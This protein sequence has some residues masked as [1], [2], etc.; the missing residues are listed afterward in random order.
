MTAPIMKKRIIKTTRAMKTTTCL[1]LGLF[2]MA[3][4][5]QNKSTAKIEGN[6]FDKNLRIELKETSSGKSINTSSTEVSSPLLN[7]KAQNTKLATILD[8][9][10]ETEHIEIKNKELAKKLF[11]FELVSSNDI[12]NQ[13]SVLASLIL[14]MLSEEYSIT[15]IF[16]DSLNIS[17]QDLNKFEHHQT[18]KQFIPGKKN[19]SIS[20]KVNNHL[21]VENFTLDHL[22]K[23]ISKQHCFKYSMLKNKELNKGRELRIDYS[24]DLN[25]WEKVKLALSRDL[26]LK[27]EVYH[28]KSYKITVE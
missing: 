24:I 7:A 17:I 12:A 16:D 14:P 9:I 3:C 20:T 22:L 13:D 28:I 8:L 15:P 11:D 6:Y 26:G 1:L 10:L 18:S 21:E 25:D 23:E 19:S 4:N 27:I 5:S 2:L